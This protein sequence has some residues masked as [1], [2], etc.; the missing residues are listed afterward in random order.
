[1]EENIAVFML[2][3]SV[4]IDVP[5]ILIG[6]FFCKGK[7]G[8]LLAGYNTMSRQEKQTWDEKKLLR[9]NG[10]CIILLGLL[11]IFMQVLILMGAEVKIVYGVGWTLYG[12][13][14][15]WMV[16]YQNTKRRFRR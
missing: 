16:V 1:M 2:I 7:G 8:F 11:P 15:L 5:L 12:V 6:I 4:L 3:V 9:F 13:L 14:I 10:K